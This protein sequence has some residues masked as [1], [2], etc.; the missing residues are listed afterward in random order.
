MRGGRRLLR[1]GS[2]AG[3]I[4]VWFVVAA[5]GPEILP[6][7]PSVAAALLE[8]VVRPNYWR[9]VLVSTLRVYGAFLVAVAVGVPLGLLIG[10]NVVFGDFVFPALEMLRPIPPIAWIPLT[11]LAI[12]TLELFV[13]GEAFAVKS[14]IVFITFLGAFFP[15]LLNT[16]E[17]VRGI[18]EEYRRAAET[19]GAGVGQRFR[20]VIYPGALP[21]I[22][23]GMVVGM[24]LAWVNLIAAEMIAGGGL[25]FLTWSAYTGGSYP[26]IV[27]GMI[28]IGALG[29]ASSVAIR[30]IGEYQLPWV[31]TQDVSA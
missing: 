26:V 29:Y 24:G 6:G 1:L 31:E 12:P 18:D 9:S 28:T 25:G 10:W 4:G 15:I 3:L 5:V 2:V 20:H 21:K 22:H 14:S 8:A 13:L 23:T 19:L 16:I 7:P 11:I 30:R 17:G 27:V